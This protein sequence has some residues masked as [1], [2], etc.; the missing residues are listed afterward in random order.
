[1]YIWGSG[2][3]GQLGLGIDTVKQKEPVVLPMD[4]KVIQVACGYYHTMLVTGL[5]FKALFYCICGND[6]YTINTD[7]LTVIAVGASEFNRAEF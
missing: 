7:Q 5:L 2:S 1:M 3:E 6:L 4:D